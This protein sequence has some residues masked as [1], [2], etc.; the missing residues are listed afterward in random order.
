MF[1]CCSRRGELDLAHEALGRDADGQ[2]GREHLDD[3]V[4]LERRVA[5]EKDPTHPA[6]A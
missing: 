3:D 4:A 1:A 6:A 5:H 2:V